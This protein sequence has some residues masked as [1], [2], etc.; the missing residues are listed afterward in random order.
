MDRF[1]HLTMYQHIA[2]AFGLV[3]IYICNVYRGAKAYVWLSIKLCIDILKQQGPTSTL[4]KMKS[5]QV[6]L[7]YFQ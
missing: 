5:Y 3:A 2:P 7:A 1:D 4:Q 6:F